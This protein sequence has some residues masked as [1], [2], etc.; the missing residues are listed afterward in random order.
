MDADDA[1]RWAQITSHMEIQRM[2]K[3]KQDYIDLHP[4]PVEQE[5][6]TLAIYLGAAVCFVAGCALL[7]VLMGWTP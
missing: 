4:E 5:P 2:N 3:W 1:I 6:S 7:V